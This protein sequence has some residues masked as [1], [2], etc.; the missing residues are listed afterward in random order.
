MFE[1]SFQY[2]NDCSFAVP[3]YLMAGGGLQLALAG[4][5]II[6]MCTPCD[7]DDK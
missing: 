4:A 3:T 1:Y 5:M 7:T 2:Q 6:A